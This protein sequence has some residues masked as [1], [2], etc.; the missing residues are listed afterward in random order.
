[1]GGNILAVAI[2]IERI[3]AKCPRFNNWVEKIE[4]KA[5]E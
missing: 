2:G 1:M 3:R 5:S 4:T